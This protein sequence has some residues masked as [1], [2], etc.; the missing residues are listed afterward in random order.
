[1]VDNS[2]CAICTDNFDAQHV[3]D[4]ESSWARQP[5]DAAR[6]Q[7]PGDADVRSRTCLD[8]EAHVE[9]PGKR[10]V[11]VGPGSSCV[12]TVASMVDVVASLAVAPFLISWLTF[13]LC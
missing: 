13:Q 9:S 6:E 4:S 2:C 10:M 3:V 11:P 7:E 1:M 12:P 8:R 5:A